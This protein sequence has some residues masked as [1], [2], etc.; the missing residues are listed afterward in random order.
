MVHRYRLHI[1]DDGTPGVVTAPT[2][3]GAIHAMESLVSVVMSR[4]S[5]SH[6]PAAEAATRGCAISGVPLTI[7]D[8][9]RFPHRGL[10]IDTGRRFLPVGLIEHVIDGLAMNKLNVLHWH[11][12]DS[13]SFPY[14]SQAFPR[15]SA[16]GAYS[17]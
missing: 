5:S 13:V 11:I 17:R 16:Q 8:T 7:D 1:P 14:E 6:E 12:V 10:M 9:P 2:V 15:M 3:F 4:R